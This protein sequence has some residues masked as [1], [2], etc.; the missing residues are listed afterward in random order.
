M[1]RRLNTTAWAPMIRQSD[2]GREPA[3]ACAL[4]G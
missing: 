3:P 2:G 1:K 4:I